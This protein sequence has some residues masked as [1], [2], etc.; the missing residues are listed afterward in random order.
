MIGFQTQIAFAAPARAKRSRTWRQVA[1]YSSARL[2]LSP[3]DQGR[4]SPFISAAKR[5]EYGPS[6]RGDLGGPAVDQRV[7]VAGEDAA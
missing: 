1:T 5:S 3:I 4:Q 6:I 7:V 2:P